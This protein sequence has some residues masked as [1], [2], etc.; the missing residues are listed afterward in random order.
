ME[1]HFFGGFSNL[2]DYHFP[3][4]CLPVLPDGFVL[5]LAVSTPDQS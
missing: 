2:G 5:Y 1:E 4:V 3:G